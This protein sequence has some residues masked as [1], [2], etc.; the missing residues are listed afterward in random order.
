MRTS[1]IRAALAV[2]LAIV[3]GA[4]APAGAQVLRGTV[5]H[6]NRHAHS[7][8]VALKGG[9]LRSVHARRLPAVGRLVRVDARKLGNGTFAAHGVRAHGSRTHARLR[10]TVTFVDRRAHRLVVSSHGVSLLLRTRRQRGA[11]AA[12]SLPGSGTVV[13]VDADLSEDTPVAQ[14]VTPVGTDLTVTVE[15][16]VVAVDATAGT[17]TISADD[18]DASGAQLTIAVPTGIDVSG[19]APGDQ[20]ELLVTLHSDGTYALLGLAG[21]DNAEHADDPSEQQGQPCDGG[22]DHHGDQGGSPGEDQS[23][24]DGQSSGTEGSGTG[25]GGGGDH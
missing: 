6:H 23:S 20:V 8:A 3:L 4:A 19:L 25:D 12:D 16:V 5:V 9:A 7:F 14:S 17:L 24:G 21:D 15:G 1:R 22:E 11:A 2:T 13:E 18:E 10:G